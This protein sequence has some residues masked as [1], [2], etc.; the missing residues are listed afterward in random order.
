[1]GVGH[2]PTPIG[3]PLSLPRVDAATGIVQTSLRLMPVAKRVSIADRLPDELT[4]VS[5]G[6]DHTGNPYHS[7]WFRCLVG[8]DAAHPEAAADDHCQPS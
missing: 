7:E 2:C 3:V 6:E 1:M 8:H 4:F 5:V